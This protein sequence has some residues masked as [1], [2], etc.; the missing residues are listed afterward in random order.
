MPPPSKLAKNLPQIIAEIE[1]LPEKIYKPVEIEN[2]LE[3]FRG[4]D[5]VANLTRFYEFTDVLKK[6]HLIKEIILCKDPLIIRYAKGDINI[7]SFKYLKG[8]VP[9]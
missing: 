5:L 2:L 8:I 1:K 4:K 7:F 9:N 6:E 3:E